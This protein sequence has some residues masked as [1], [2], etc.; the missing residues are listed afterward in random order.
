MPFTN[1]RALLSIA[2]EEEEEEEDN[3]KDGGGVEREEQQHVG[4]ECLEL[5][6]HV[7]I[8]HTASSL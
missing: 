8:K 4:L 6:K 2:Q 3:D 5:I 7:F 1:L